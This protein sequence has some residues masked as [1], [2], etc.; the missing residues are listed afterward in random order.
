LIG[1]IVSHYEVIRKLGEGG[2]GIVYLARDRKLDRLVALKYLPAQLASSPERVARFKDEARAISALNHPNIATIYGI[3]ESDS[4]VFL[5]FEYLSGGTLNETLA[6]ENS[7]KRPL[8][9]DRVIEY[10]IQIAAGLAHAHEHRVIHRDIKTS[11]LMLT[12]A[13][14]VKITDFGLA[15]LAEGA[16]V[17]GAG[18][19]LGTPSYMSPE[20]A[21][22]STV[23]HRSDIFSFGV[24]L[25]EMLTG[26]QPF[27][28]ATPAAVLYEIVHQPAPAAKQFRAGVPPGLDSILRRALEK[29]PR[30]RY[31]NAG[32]LLTELRRLQQRPEMNTIAAETLT[33]ARPRRWLSLAAVSAVI[34]LA[35]AMVWTRSAARVRLPNEKYL[36]VLPFTCSPASAANQ[37]FCNGLVDDLTTQIAR[38]QQFH[39]SLAV[40]PASDVRRDAPSNAQQAGRKFGVK[41][42][43]AGS[44]HRTEDRVLVS[45]TLADASNSRALQSFQKE[46]QV[47]DPASLQRGV[48]AE[49]ARMLQ[50]E[51]TPQSRQAIEAGDTPVGGAYDLYLKGRGHL[52]G[53]DRAEDI[54][55]AVEMFQRARERDPGYALAY[56]G[57]AEA[58]VRKFAYTGDT[59]FLELAGSNARRAS[60]LNDGLSEVHVTAGVVSLDQG[61]YSEAVDEFKRAL[62]LDPMSADATRRLASAYQR[63]GNV[64]EA[65]A[66]YE[67]AIKLRPQYYAVYDNFGVFLEQNGHLDRAE[68]YLRRG[69]E[70]NPLYARGW[71]N[72]GSLYLRMGREKDAEQSLRKS[73]DVEPTPEAYSNLGFLFEDQNRYPDAI[74]YLEK[75][76]KLEPS[77]Y[78]A[79]GNLADGYRW[80]P[81][82][83]SKAPAAYDQAIQLAEKRLR[84]NPKE[85]A[86][87]SR[88]AVYQALAQHGDRAALEIAHALKQAPANM[89]VLYDSALVYELTGRREQAI[90]S[91]MAA[92]KAGYSMEVIR[93]EPELARMQADSRLA[94]LLTR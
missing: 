48:A 63:E 53:S 78:L 83:A 17:T 84:I 31:Q 28:G 89:T 94:S 29:S 92:I 44:I 91:L 19:A 69:V 56:A 70:L 10:A 3:E 23:D 77:N 60:E 43:L 79:W 5:V 6:A 50:L 45:A 20:Q 12:E 90:Q 93:K 33:P 21:E 76:V 51:L 74:P 82:L 61:N 36:A 88:M 71:N 24:V 46:F 26:R 25:F 2:M 55:S 54:D 1:R 57:I 27:E 14:I 73:L 7:K 65:E 9:L 87:R 64:T 47:G 34:L 37:D 85:A 59:Q 41:L 68:P 67:K 18:T 35:G 62:Q 22:G 8:T 75:A 11:N 32:E 15:K 72:L 49:V 58:F 13:G 39:G 66:A 16:Q 38:L 4:E 42:A 30:D 86:L 52:Q 80:S 40:V 81:G